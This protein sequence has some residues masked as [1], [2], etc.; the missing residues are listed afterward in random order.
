MFAVRSCFP[1]LTGLALLASA[2]AC[3][4]SDAA[5]P[6]T[7][8]PPAGTTTAAA[9]PSIPATSGALPP[10]ADA[11]GWR[12]SF[13]RCGDGERPVL[14]IGALLGTTQRLAVCEEPGGP[15]VLR[16][17]VPQLRAQPFEAKFFTFTANSQQFLAAD[18][19]KLDLSRQMVTITDDPQMKRGVVQSFTVG[20]YWSTF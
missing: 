5:S 19:M 10:A 1:V 18:G 20:E 13:A 4:G 9:T 6:A 3:S 17:D 8:T 12:D 7:S 15:R 2:A 14:L 11:Q 16:A